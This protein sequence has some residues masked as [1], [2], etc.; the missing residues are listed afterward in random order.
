MQSC[1]SLCRDNNEDN[2]AVMKGKC[3]D[4]CGTEVK[5]TYAVKTLCKRTIPV[6]CEKNQPICVDVLKT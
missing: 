2:L 4:A 5:K 1:M 3:L 6:V